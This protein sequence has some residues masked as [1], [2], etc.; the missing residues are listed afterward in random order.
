MGFTNR[1][2][3]FCMA[4]FTA[5]ALDGTSSAN[6]AQSRQGER[7]TQS[8]AAGTPLLAVIALAQQRI[9][10]YGAS[11]KIM[12][13]PV[14]TGVR[15]RDTPAGIYSILEKEEEHHSNLYDDATMPFMQRLTW[16]GIA[17]HAGVVPGY[18]ASHGCTRLSYGFAQKLYPATKLGMR[19]VIVR[20]DIGPVEIEQPEMFD[21]G[22][23]PEPEVSPAGINATKAPSEA[24][25]QVRLQVI[26][27]AKMTEA[28]AARQR[29][30]KARSAAVYKGA[31][32][33]SAARVAEAAAADLAR[34]EA[35]LEAAERMPQ[36]VSR[37]AEDGEAAR[38]AAAARI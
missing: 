8:H 34:M 38:T 9:S 2:A 27:D 24:D 1:A 29:E 12:E 32:A 26:K 3:I 6:A 4:G 25:R 21:H 15:G 30:L 37:S 11:G 22:R 13:A 35:A 23:P 17:M 36:T 7:S 16:T 18:P 19:V 14:S 33:A 10:L 20:E 31:E 28:E 5:V